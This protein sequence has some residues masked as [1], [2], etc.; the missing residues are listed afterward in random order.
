MYNFSDR[1][2]NLKG[3]AIREIFKLLSN[4][5]IISF[6][7]GF[8]AKDSLPDTD[9][10]NIANGLLLS[11]N[12]KNLLQYGGTEGYFPLL[13]S[14]VN[15]CKRSG[16]EASTKEALVISGGQQ[17]IDLTFKAFLNKGDKILVENPTYLAVLHILKTYEGVAVGVD[18]EADGLDM[19][20]LERKII[21]NNPKII[22]V[23]PNFSN[24][25][26]KTLSLAKRKK[27]A[28]LSKKYNVIVIEDDPY[29]EIRF[30]NDRLP[31]IKSFDT[32]GNV[33]YVTSFSKTIAPGLRTGIAIAD[34]EIIRKLTIGK[35]AVDVHTSTLSQAIVDKYIRNGLLEPHIKDIIPLYSAKKQA[36]SDAIAKYMPKGISFTNPDG[37]LF[38][39][40][41]FDRKDINT[42]EIFADVVE[43]T[44][45]A[46]VPGSSFFASEN[47]FNTFRLNYSNATLAQIDS[48]IKSLGDYFKKL[49]EA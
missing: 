5:S 35:Q 37:G 41:E 30:A 14:A 33:I 47:V 22:Y 4:P 43:K 40:A 45:C 26:G 46:Y 8:P 21:E 42:D 9:I 27:I 13:E 39:F 15:W 34:S 48:G 23:V 18:S 31:A 16:I 25:T 29:G 32:V 44:K 11:E 12:A 7:G 3:N 17:G 1:I 19:I 49:L 36:M 38:I 10:A 24:P 6:A 2:K 28:E 20:D